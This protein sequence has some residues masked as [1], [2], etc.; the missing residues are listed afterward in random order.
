MSAIKRAQVGVSIPD[1]L[2]QR[3]DKASGTCC[4]AWLHVSFSKARFSYT[5]LFN[6]SRR[7]HAN[8]R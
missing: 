3:R 8:R 7:M 5:P 2:R 1:R 4:L 6:I